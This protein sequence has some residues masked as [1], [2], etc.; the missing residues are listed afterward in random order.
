MRNSRPC[1]LALFALACTLAA[2]GHLWSQQ[3][4]PRERFEVPDRVH[5]SESTLWSLLT[6]Q[7]LP[8]YPVD[9]QSKAIQGKVVLKLHIEKDGRVSS[10]ATV[11]G[12]SLLVSGQNGRTD[13][14]SL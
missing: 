6:N 12:D 5:L 2:A 14:A 9:A 4:D 8:N 11:S 10:V 7:V 1:S 13:G 3:F